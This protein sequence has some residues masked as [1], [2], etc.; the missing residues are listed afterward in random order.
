MDSAIVRPG[1]NLQV[2]D[3]AP[4]P[5]L[6]RNAGAEATRRYIEFFTANIRN[7]NTRLA[8]L[9]AVT[10]FADW[11]E[12]REVALNQLTPVVVAAYIE[13]ASQTLSAL[14]VKQH[15]TAIRMLFDYFVIGQVMSSNPARVVRGPKHVVKFGKTPVLSPEETRQLLDSI[16]AETVAGLRDWALVGVMVY[17]FARVSAV[18]KMNVGD[19]SSKGRRGWFRLHE[20]GGKYHEVP[21]HHNVEGYVDAYLDKTGIGEQAKSPF[22]RSLNRKRTLTDHRI[23]RRAVWRMIKRRARRA[24]LP[25]TICCHTFRATGITTYLKT[26]GTIEATQQIAAHESPRTT[27][28]YDWRWVRPHPATVTSP[29]KRS[30]GTHSSL[31]VWARCWRW[32]CRE[33]AEPR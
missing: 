25:E 26:G 29:G 6:V 20:K 17:S 22:F 2:V 31:R 10:H 11:C 24:A 4:V 3:T 13:Q 8:Y 1:T 7:K 14:T 33:R 23:G 5:A 28:L 30:R 32:L 19:Y 12:V 15:L 21:A 18:I 9:A 16:N 27:K